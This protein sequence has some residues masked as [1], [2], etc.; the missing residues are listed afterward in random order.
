MALPMN[1]NPHG[2]DIGAVCRRLGL[3]EA[4]AIQFDFSVNVNPLGPPP[5]LHTVLQDGIATAARYPERHA[6]TAARALAQ[7]HGVDPASVLVSNGSTEAFSWVLQALRPRSATLLIPCYAGYEEVCHAHGTPIAE[8]IALDPEHPAAFP[9]T[10]VAQARGEVIFVGTPNNP[11][12]HLVDPALLRRVANQ[13]PERLV[14]A[15]E[16]FIDFTPPAEHA[17][18]LPAPLPRNLMVIKSLTKF[19]AIPGLRLGMLCAH[20]DTAAR[21][22]DVRLPWSVNGLAQAIAPNLYGHSDYLAATRRTTTELREWMH[23]QL[24]TLTGCTPLPASANYLLMRLPAA[25]PA[26]RLQR[27]L[28]PQGILIRSCENV[29]GLGSHWCRLAVRPRPEITALMTALSPLFPTNALA[30]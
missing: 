6:D 17:S 9:E 20:P 14:V 1:E 18:L 4:P 25:W 24:A 29:D 3:R 11:T 7:A 16:S 30:H 12:G 2:G 28:L 10:A 8:S 19:F 5:S 13:R 26:D 27:A 21:L 22:A 15:D 23:R